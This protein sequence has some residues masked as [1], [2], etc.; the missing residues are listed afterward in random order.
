MRT[1]DKIWLVKKMLFNFYSLKIDMFC[2]VF[3]S[4]L[5]DN[6]WGRILDKYYFTWGYNSIK[7]VKHL[8]REGVKKM[9]QNL[10]KKIF[11]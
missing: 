4:S 1:S 9:Q 11:H 6:F 8:L 5:S 2:P 10:C 7:E 3:I